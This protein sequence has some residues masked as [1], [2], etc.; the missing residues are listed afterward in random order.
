MVFTVWC[1]ED[2]QVWWL[3]VLHWFGP[4]SQDSN[5]PT[6]NNTHIHPH[7]Q[8]FNFY[9]TD[10]TECQAI[11]SDHLVLLH[12][13][14]WFLWAHQRANT[15]RYTKHIWACMHHRAINITLLRVIPCH[16][17]S[18]HI[19]GHIFWQS[20]HTLK[21]ICHIFWKPVWHSIWH[22]FFGHVIFGTLSEI[23]WHSI[24]YEFEQSCI[25]DDKYLTFWHIVWHT[26]Q[27]SFWHSTWHICYQSSW[28]STW[29]FIWQSIW[30]IFWQS[31]WHRFWQSIWYIFGH[32]I[33]HFDIHV[34]ILSGILCDIV[35]DVPSDISSAMLSGI[36]F[37]HSYK[38]KV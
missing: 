23:C 17:M 35:P 1:F 37:W 9:I 15:T 25:L 10:L 6:T 21:S 3:L 28:H 24:W 11:F 20:I 22:T 8:I 33:W 16:D 4:C 30:H 34:D 19:F 12:R 7:V 2:L 36:W 13:F 29:T 38:G 14:A 27:H 32:I 18:R 31:I 26:F 5:I